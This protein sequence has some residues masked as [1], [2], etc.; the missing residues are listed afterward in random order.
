V[1]TVH[2]EQMTELVYQAL[3]TELGGVQ[4]YEAAVACAV[5]DDLKK[6]WQKYLEQTRNHVR[7]ATD[8]VQR[9]GLDPTVETP[10][11]Q[12]V[13][14]K[15]AALVRSMEMARSAGDPW[16]APRGGGGGRGGARGG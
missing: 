8:L 5:N 10:G 6:E 16:G 7:V 13:R 1:V 3:E 4:V 2:E 12:I 11:R 9:M 15:A 14:E